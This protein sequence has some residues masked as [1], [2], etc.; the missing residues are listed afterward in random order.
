MRR[1]ATLKVIALIG[2]LVG[3]VPVR[4]DETPADPKASVAA[5][6]M[7]VMAAHAGTI[8]T[9]SSEAGFPTRLQDKP[10]FR[11]DD[12]TRGY[13]DGTVWRL[14]ET[15]RPRAIV[16][17]ELH[18]NYLGG[19]P[20]VVYD[21]FSLNEQP[22][23]AASGTFQ[24]NPPDSAVEIQPLPRGPVPSASAP[25]RLTQIK[26][27][28]RRFTA[29]QEIEETDRTLVQLRRLPREID[30]YQSGAAENSDGALFLFVNGRNPGLVLLIETDGTNWQFGV[31]RLSAPSTLTLK[32][33]DEVVWTQPRAGL[34]TSSSYTA[35]NTPAKFP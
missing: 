22:F 13:V 35:T 12:E 26:D 5:E 6:R 20:R 8:R 14:G 2:L 27:L 11:Y 18:P 29:T 19:G 25:Q 1:R 23:R 7:A 31:G 24:W 33:D 32:L 17:T 34:G 15:G 10:L 9:T 16:T 30:R 21:A 3:I 28:S 4:A